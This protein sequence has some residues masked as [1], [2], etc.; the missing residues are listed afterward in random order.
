MR[1]YR[2]LLKIPARELRANQT[3]A[4]NALWQRVRRKQIAGLQF[5]R[6]KPLLSFIVDFYCPAAEL[7]IELDGSQH[8]EPEH[9]ERDRERDARL[10]SIGLTV[11]RFDNRQVLLELD[12]VLTIVR[13]TATGRASNR[14]LGVG[15]GPGVT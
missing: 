7:V 14:T 5:Y 11:L 8:R 1:R 3:E 12:G 10:S 4:E 2:S 13:D 9:L 15:C 6:Q